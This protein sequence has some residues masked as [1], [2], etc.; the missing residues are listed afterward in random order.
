MQRREVLRWGMVPLVAWMAG[1]Q[2]SVEMT[3][4]EGD[5]SEVPDDPPP[6][7]EADEAD[8][9]VIREVTREGFPDGLW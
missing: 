7:I 2:E 4:F 3:A 8:A 1:C 5:T 9:D 6:G